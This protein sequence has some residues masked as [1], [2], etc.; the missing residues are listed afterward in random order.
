MFL[1]ELYLSAKAHNGVLNYLE[2]EHTERNS[3][4]VGE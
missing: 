3:T 4:Y 2:P 1:H